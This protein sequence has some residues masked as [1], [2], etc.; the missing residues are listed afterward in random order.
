MA[1]GGHLPRPAESGLLTFDRSILSTEGDG[2]DEV[3]IGVL[4][5]AKV[6][7]KSLLKPARRVPEARVVAVAA[8]DQTRARTYAAKHAIPRV[9]ATYEALLADPAIDAVYVPL[10]NAVHAQWT[11]RAMQAGK[12]VLCE[13]PFTANAAQARRVAD[14]AQAS[15]L[16]VMEALHYR[17]HPL[18]ARMQQISHSGE[19]GELRHIETSTC[20]PEPAF[21]SHCYRYELAGGALMDAGCYAVHCLRLLGVGEPEVI[22]ARA[23]LIRPQ[24][25]RAMTAALRFPD[26]A[27]GRTTCSLRS[28]HLLSF[29][30]R[31]VGSRGELRVSN[32][33]TPQVLHRMAIRPGGSHGIRV[34]GEATYVPP[35]PRLHGRHPPRRAGAHPTGRLGG[36]D[37]ADRPDLPRRGPA[38]P[39]GGLSARCRIPP[40]C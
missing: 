17:Y 34:G 26:G 32:Y 16:V 20:Y 8:R 15:G 36:L 6:T 25:D 30:A 24:V 39:R 21:T 18:A 31:V 35:A 22:S 2:V 1:S 40:G 3:R 7:P 5:A 33:L 4:G 14:A 27:T 37:A 9:H 12:H 13:K 11:L 28:A 19:L 23:K 10:V 29:R 38:A